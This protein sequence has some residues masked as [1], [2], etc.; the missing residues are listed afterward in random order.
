MNHK[1]ISV[2]NNKFGKGV[3][4]VKKIRP[5]EV[6]AIFDGPIFDDDFNG[7]TKD[8]L[9][10][11]IQIGKTLWRDSC[12]PARY[13]NHSCD[14]NCGIKKLNRIVAMKTIYPG[15][16]ITW[17]YE[18]SEHSWWWKMRCRCKSNMCRK[19]IGDYKNMPAKTR[20]K[21]KGFISDWLITSNL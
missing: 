10:H 8:I 13:I 3:Y 2:R 14:P 7:W 12:G 1:K 4:A 19:K 18:M 20:K 5:R 6:V 21:Y 11:A 16:E 15:E 9:N 17:D